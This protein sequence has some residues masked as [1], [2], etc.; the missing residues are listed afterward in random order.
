MMLS[1]KEEFI[2]TL[3]VSKKRKDYWIIKML[4]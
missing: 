3:L 1:Q 4:Y 2:L